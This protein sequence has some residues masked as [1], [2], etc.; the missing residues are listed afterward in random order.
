MGSNKKARTKASFDIGGKLVLYSS[1]DGEGAPCIVC[2]G[3][4][5]GHV[6][7]CGGKS[8][9]SSISQKLSS[10]YFILFVPVR[11]VVLRALKFVWCRRFVT[12]LL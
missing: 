1:G 6:E 5:L 11:K 8:L 2:R 4:W 3:D 12:K 9:C 10:F 7:E